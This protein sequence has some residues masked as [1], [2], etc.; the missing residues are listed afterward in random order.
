MTIT[1]TV[2]ATADPFFSGHVYPCASREEAE[3]TA[4]RLCRELPGESVFVEFFRESDS[5]R[6]YL[7]PDG[8]FSVTGRTWQ[9]D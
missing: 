1:Y 4:R 2:T 3:E 6:G 5:Q 7:N 9:E 8:S